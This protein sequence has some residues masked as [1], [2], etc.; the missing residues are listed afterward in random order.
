MIPVIGGMIRPMT[1]LTQP[2][3]AQVGLLPGVI[4]VISLPIRTLM[5]IIWKLIIQ[6]VR[7]IPI[8]T[9]GIA[10]T[11]IGVAIGDCSNLGQFL[12]Q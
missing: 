6:A 4:A 7:P 8:T 3:K 9:P 11:P 2:I 1:A 12:P 10:E 5:L